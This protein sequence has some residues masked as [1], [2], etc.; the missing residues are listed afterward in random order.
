MDQPDPL[1]P[2]QPA[3]V[4]VGPAGREELASQVPRSLGDLT[5]EYALFTPALIFTH[6][7]LDR[8]PLQDFIMANSLT[9]ETGPAIVDCQWPLFSGLGRTNYQNEL[10]DWNRRI[11]GCPLDY[12]EKLRGFIG[13]IVI[14]EASSL[15]Y[16][17]V[18]WYDLNIV[19]PFE[20]HSGRVLDTVPAVSICVF[21]LSANRGVFYLEPATDPPR[22]LPIVTA[23]PA[24]PNVVREAEAVLGPPMDITPLK[25]KT[26]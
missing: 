13:G 24:D 2:L 14:T 21:M 15:F 25:E 23:L 16:S 5:R 4:D 11:Y 19:D 18:G 17:K 26:S 12:W 10:V 6:A 22:N 8:D 7:R 3:P 1:F 9:T 20:L